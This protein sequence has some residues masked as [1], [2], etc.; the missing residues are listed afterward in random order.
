VKLLKQ[1]GTEVTTHLNRNRENYCGI[2][3]QWHQL[4]HHPSCKNWLTILC[5][6]V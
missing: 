1:S 6:C 2:C 3:E 4:S 5:E